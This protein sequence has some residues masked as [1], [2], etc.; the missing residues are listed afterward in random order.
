MRVSY[1]PDYYVPLPVGH[2]FPM[3]KFP[4]LHRILSAEGLIAAADVVEPEEATW[5]LLGVVHT[6]DYLDCLR[7]GTLGREAERR[8]GLPWSAQLAR[9]SR[10]AVR[11]TLNAAEMALEDGIA[12]NL[13]GGTHHAFAGH[14]EGFC[15]L[16]DVAVTVRHLTAMGRIRRSLV[17]DLDVHQGN[18]TA[19]ILADD[20]AAFTLS[21]HGANNYPFR[22]T[23]SDLDLPLPDGTGDGA[24]L[25]LLAS[26]LP[27]LLERQRPD[28]VF[29][30]AGVDVLEGDR[31]GRLSLTREGLRR[32]DRLVIA[33]AAER[34]TPMVVLMSGGYAPNATDTADLHAI[35]HREAREL[36]G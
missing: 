36:L 23:E 18:G 16:N 29:Y 34:G 31:Y 8:L 10:L 9:R 20:P 32:R 27:A 14:G 35:A 11:G 13:A 28:L 15:V 17:V 25:E 4:E 22:K 7:T 6:S 33:A 12:A 21:M 2:P 24:Y 1:C 30:L 26:Q 5:E 19:T 3:A